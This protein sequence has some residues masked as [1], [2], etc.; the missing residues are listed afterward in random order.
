VIYL[1]LAFQ[2]A[3]ILEMRRRLKGFNPPEAASWFLWFSQIIYINGDLFTGSD[4]AAARWMTYS[5]LNHP[6]RLVIYYTFAII[7]FSCST[8]GMSRLSTSISELRQSMLAIIRRAAVFEPYMAGIVVVVLV[9]QMAILNWDVVLSNHTYLLLG[10]WEATKVDKSIGALVLSMAG[11]SSLL[12]S[13]FLAISLSR[14]FNAYTIVWSAAFSWQL[15][16]SVAASSRASAMLVGIVVIFS[17][18]FAK[19]ASP[20][21]QVA[22]LLCAGWLYCSALGG[23]GHGHFGLTAIPE[24]LASPLELQTKQWL[25]MLASV[26]QGAFITGDGLDFTANFNPIYKML[27]FSPLPSVIDHFSTYLAL[28]E[29]R[30]NAFV[31]MGAQTEV[32]FFGPGYTA[33]FWGTLFFLCR[34]LIKNKP[35][36]GIFYYFGSLFFLITFMQTGAYPTRSVY[37]TFFLLLIFGMA[38]ANRNRNAAVRAR[39]DARPGPRPMP[40][41]R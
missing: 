33:L 23:R 34:T 21:R 18:L 38:L 39:A 29:I 11:A 12:S 8:L 1:L 31:P 3:L 5:Y 27:S 10:S 20:L 35:Y 24:I 9:T 19:R 4:S 30:L 6:E 40:G 17:S 22:L 36:I 37:R 2:L 14:R 32:V 13:M 15:A 28:Y 41:Q 25:E 7:M 16:F 26:F